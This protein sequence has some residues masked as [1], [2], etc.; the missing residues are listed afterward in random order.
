MGFL[1]GPM[2]GMLAMPRFDDD[3]IGM[4]ELIR[5]LTGQVLNAI[6]D[7]VTDRLCAG[8]VSSRNGYRERALATRV[9]TLTPCIPKLRTG[10]FFLNDVI[11]LHQDPQ[12]AAHRRKDGRLEILEER[13]RRHRGVA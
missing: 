1:A 10:G 2:P 8:G 13:G 5:R 3:V 11:E 4:L 9:D 6:M 7:A 12:G